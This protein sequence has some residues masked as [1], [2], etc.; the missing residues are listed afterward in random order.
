VARAVA[1][2]RFAGRAVVVSGGTAGIG[3]AVAERLAAEGASLVVG[4]RRPDVS[5]TV[6][7]GIRD[8]GGRAV[9]VRADA[10]VEDDAAALVAAAVSQ[11]G[12]LDGAVN[13]AG[14]VTATGPLPE[15]TA[16]AWRTELDHNLT[17]VF[18]GLKHQIPVLNVDTPL[19]RRLLG[20]GPDERLEGAPNP[21]GRVARP[22]EIAAF[23]A[24]LLSDEA[25]FVTGAAL[26]VDGGA[27][28]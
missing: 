24:F 20:A 6:V 9:F 21:T 22:E 1:Q 16:D 23:V 17:S 5:D 2:G 13:N 14:G 18:F 28:A 11:F 12:R 19:Y 27:T 15:V 26:A 25:A 8:A 4:A 7:E 3:R 10:T